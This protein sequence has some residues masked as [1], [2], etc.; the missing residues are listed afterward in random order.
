VLN[1]ITATDAPPTAQTTP[2]Q[3]SLPTDI[4]NALQSTASVTT[5]TLEAKIEEECE[6]KSIH[7]MIF[8]A[9]AR[10]QSHP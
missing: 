5:P 4:L 6:G 10:D 2:Q 3:D 9:G 8:V 7:P 1:P